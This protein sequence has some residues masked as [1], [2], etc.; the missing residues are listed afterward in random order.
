M[1]LQPTPEVSRT[2]H[3]TCTSVI[4]WANIKFRVLYSQR[5]LFNAIPDTNHNANPTNPN[6][7]SKDNP[8]PTNPNTKYRCEYG[9]LNS[10]FARK[11][12][13][14]AFENCARY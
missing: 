8:T 6:R 9:T 12:I 10:M 4:F 11:F 7:N 3:Q 5:Y 1:C 2:V 13:L 14:A